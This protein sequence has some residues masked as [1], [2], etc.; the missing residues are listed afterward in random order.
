MPHVP[1]HTN[2]EA[3][4]NGIMGQGMPSPSQGMPPQP[5]MTP[6]DFMSFAQRNQQAQPQPQ[7][8]MEGL[9][10]GNNPEGQMPNDFL[11]QIIRAL[12]LRLQQQQIT[13]QAP[14]QS[15]IMPDSMQMDS[16]TLMQSPQ[17]PGF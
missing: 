11:M 10:P 16:Q 2:T 12:I 6:A 13:Q 5:V 14:T 8:T 15:P 4:L 1:G 9:M 17:A 3:T 7:P